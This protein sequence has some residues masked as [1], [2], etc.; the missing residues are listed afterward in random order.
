MQLANTIEQLDLAADHLA[1]GD[2]N[3]A[4]FALMLCDNI[5]ELTLHQYAKDK[6][7]ELKAFSWRNEAFEHGKALERALGRYFEEMVKS[8]FDRQAVR[9][10]K[11]EHSHR[12]LGFVM[13]LP[14]RRPHSMK[15]C[16]LPSLRSFPALHANFVTDYK[17]IFM[18]IQSRP[19]NSGAN[20][21]VF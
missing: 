11:R 18:G 17:V 8:S 3:N 10:C 7:I 4:R 12:T 21:E 20:E 15:Q 9:G 14:V 1:P 5:V 13:M 6:R 16:C 2:A 19:A